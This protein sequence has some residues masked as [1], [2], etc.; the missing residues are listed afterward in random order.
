LLL[1]NDGDLILIGG[2]SDWATWGGNVPLQLAINGGAPT[3][4]TAGTA[5]NLIMVLVKDP[6]LLARLRAAKTLDW[7]IP[8]G[9]VHGEVAGLGVALDAAKA[10]K[11]QAAG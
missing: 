10:C 8:T 5:A 4:L 11:A 3:P 1:N 2:H 9:H 7:T 6:A